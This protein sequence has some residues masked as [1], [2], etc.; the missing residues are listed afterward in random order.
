M[1]QQ[2]ESTFEKKSH[3][4]IN[5]LFSFGWRAGTVFKGRDWKV[6]SR[7]EHY[8]DEGE[9]DDDTDEVYAVQIL[10]IN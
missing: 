6:Y 4:Q 2:K 5:I 1:E 3:Y 10:T 7:V 9:I 8:D